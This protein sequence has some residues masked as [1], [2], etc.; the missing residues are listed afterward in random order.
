[1]KYHPLVAIDNIARHKIAIS[2]SIFILYPGMLQ[3]CLIK[4]IYHIRG[5]NPA[6]QFIL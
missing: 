5:G 4:N 3:W 2:V 6:I 1:M